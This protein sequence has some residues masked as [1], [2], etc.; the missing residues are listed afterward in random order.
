[1]VDPSWTPGDDYERLKLD[2]CASEDSAVIVSNTLVAGHSLSGND[3][4]QKS[5]VTITS[6]YLLQ[7]WYAS[8]AGAGVVVCCQS[9]YFG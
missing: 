3:G 6:E 7:V 1:M 5:L 9:W 8:R 2:H 4:C